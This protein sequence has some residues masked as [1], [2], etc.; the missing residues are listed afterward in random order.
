MGPHAGAASWHGAQVFTIGHSTRTLDELVALLRAFDV[1]I[2][3]DVRTVPRSRRNPQFDT[4]ALRR[5][6]AERGLRYVHLPELGGLRHP[7]KDSPNTGWRNASFRG[8]ADYM[9]SEKFAAGLERLRALA[10]EGRVALMCAEAV[11]WRC[12]R[13]LIA[14]ALSVRDAEV[15]HIT[16]ARQASPHRMTPFARV[17]G[18]VVFYPAP[19]DIAPSPAPSGPEAL[20]TEAPFHLEATVRVLQRRPTNPV[21]LW[22]DGR[23]RR[24]LATSSGLVLAE[25]ANEGSV[26]RPALRLSLRPAG[27]PSGARAEVAATLRRMLGL[28]VP[29]GPLQR[30]AAAVPAL[31]ATARALRGMRPP[32]Y[33]SLFEAFANVLPFQ[34]VSLDAG[35]AIVRRLVERFGEPL[36]HEGRRFRAFPAAS[37][38]AETRPSAL[39]ACGLSARKA[40]AL[41]AI[42]REIASGA[43]REDAVAA[44]ESD[45]AVRVLCAL[46]GV[47][48]WSAGLV[49]LRGL[50]RLDVFPPGDVGARRGLTELLRL[51]APAQL[52]A[53]LER[54]GAQRGHLYFFALGASLLAKGLIAPAPPA[55]REA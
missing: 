4:D 22:E 46:P 31:R 36:E 9:A 49:L 54:L 3:A 13:S 50:G 25:V 33:P 8:F 30:A 41:R 29:P 11:P 28:D 26:D 23:H 40:E 6:L 12:H 52:D 42:A 27:A 32:R 47:G 55:R 19:A 20:S 38:V 44:L 53:V 7:R 34:Q 35:V 48:P 43:L 39:R 16:S 5:S 17:E 1:A 14:D 21:D 10:G 37:A 18:S 24:V 45:E 2:V 51:D 15:R